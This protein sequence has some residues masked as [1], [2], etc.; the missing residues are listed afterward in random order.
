MGRVL[1]LLASATAV[2]A[3]IHSPELPV[4]RRA[5]PAPPNP[6]MNAPSITF[7]NPKAAEYFVDGTKIPDVDFDPGPSWS[8]E[9]AS[10]ASG[11]RSTTNHA[12]VQA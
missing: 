3:V 1:P 9:L 2:L 5:E 10:L 8:G 12:Y 4:D 7:A 11:S 6:E